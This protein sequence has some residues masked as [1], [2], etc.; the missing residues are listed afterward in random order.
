MNISVRLR[1]LLMASA[2]TGILIHAPA[3]FA[4]T[5][6]SAASP[7]APEAEPQAAEQGLGDII[8]TAQKRSENIRDVPISI[9]ALS[10]DT[11]TRSGVTN[12]MQLTSVV[13]GLKMD[14]VGPA[15]IPAIRGVST[16]VTQPGTDPNVA[17]YVDNIYMS[18]G[19]ALSLDLPDVSRIDVLKGPQGTLFGRNATGGA[20]QIFTK[21]PQMQDLG[22][23]FSASYGRFDDLILKG[24]LTGPI[25]EDTLAVGVSGYYERADS[26]YNN[27]V[28]GVRLNKIK[29]HAFRAKIL[30]TPTDT[31]RVLISGFTG[32]HSDASAELWFPL[33]GIT[34]AKAFPGAVIPTKAYD[35]ATNVPIPE[36][37]KTD[38]ASIQ[39]SQET[40]VGDIDLRASYFRATTKETTPAFAGAPPAPFTGVNYYLTTRDKSKSVELNFASRKFGGF[41]F[42]AGANYYYNRNVWDP[43]KIVTDL[44]GSASAVTLTGGQRTN[45]YAFYGEATYQLTD[46][47]SVIGGLRYSHEKRDLIG[48]FVSG[49][50]DDAPFYDWGSR[51]FNSLTQRASV[52]YEASANTNLYF[53]YSTGF[54]SGNFDTTTI[55]FGQTPAQCAAA[56]A[57]TPGSCAAPI[58]VKPE[59]I[60]AFEVGVKSAPSSWLHVD[61]ALFAY[62][63]TDIQILLFTNRCLNAP[64]PPNATTSLGQLSNA[65]VAKMYGAEVN[66]DAQ[67]TNELRLTAGI[68][69]LDAS[70]SSY[71]NASW[72]L[73]NAS[74][75]GQVLTPAASATG[76]QLPRAPKA[77]MN[78]SATYTKELDVGKLSFSA[79]GYASERVYYDVGNVYSQ[80]PYATLGLSA[81]FSPA[82][83][84]G[85]TVTLWG[86]NVT[87]TKRILGN[88]LNSTCACVSYAPPATYGVRVGYTF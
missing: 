44:P 87:D 49:A 72:N 84:E 66:V 23:D 42:I 78:V 75:T 43:N 33:N 73:P 83:L 28:P 39:I 52:R 88:F 11:L 34:L 64:C 54:K 7:Q 62:R 51:T 14:R 74:G 60:T 22:G 58:S 40:S 5:A 12:S 47:L 30:F 21:D 81:S 9:T 10:S 13:P 70:F 8:V 27:L 76:K 63:L 2:C 26:Y 4:Q 35:V 19:A 41:S 38:N 56:N 3:A 37:S 31:T 55:P 50:V 82:D 17:T 18:S 36:T 53:T 65:A 71:E 46:A 16:F 24:F 61:A 6:P 80:K 32:K 86:E 48:S 59:K 1:R 67:V 45:A 85:L 29:N 15:T 69:L 77:T 57:A 79:N 68:S 20:I 25:I